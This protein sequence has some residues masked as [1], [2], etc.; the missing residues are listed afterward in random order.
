M[1]ENYTS[2]NEYI[3]LFPNDIREI[4]MKIREIIKEE[5]PEAEEAIAYGMPTFRMSGK[6]LIHF[7]AFKDHISIFSAGA[8][9]GELENELAP[10]RTGKGTISFSLDKP[11]PYELIEGIVRAR[12]IQAQKH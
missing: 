8:V 3:G 11:I 10:Y 5:S 12:M 2:I 7:A 1:K 9:L 6:N 4:L